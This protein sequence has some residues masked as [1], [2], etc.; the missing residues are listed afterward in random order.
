MNLTFRFEIRKPKTEIRRG[1]TLIELLVVIA[2]IAILAALLLPALLHAK[3]ESKTA[4]CLNNLRQLQLAWRSYA[5]DNED[6]LVPN[7]SRSIELVQQ[8]VAPSWVLGNAKEDRSATNIQAGLLY[9]QIIG[10]V[11]VY[12]CPS[13]AS[14]CDGPSPRVLRTRSYSLSGWISNS[15]MEGKG[16]KWS[17]A[18][19]NLPGHHIIKLSEIPA[20]AQTFVFIDEHEDSIDDG[21]FASGEIKLNNWMELPSDRHRRGCNL[22]F[23]D[24]H[25]EHWRWKAPKVFT[26]YDQRPLPG[27]DTVDLKRLQACLP[28]NK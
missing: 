3:Q 25:V 15:D 28:E 1:F 5:D 12:R 13:D 22:S 11:G 26:D 6:R 24:G 7:T 18:N 4:S 2:I 9:P 8:G 21:I 14:F 19:T 27:P 16:W 10:G 20:A 17:P 23:A